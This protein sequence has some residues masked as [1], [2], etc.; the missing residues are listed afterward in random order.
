MDD[1]RARAHPLR[2]W[3]VCP[4]EA[5]GSFCAVRRRHVAATSWARSLGSSQGCGLLH[6]RVVSIY[7]V[8]VM[9]LR[10]RLA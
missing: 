5:D 4:T 7:D 10:Q 6:A 9:A 3:R 8:T 1:E 2:R